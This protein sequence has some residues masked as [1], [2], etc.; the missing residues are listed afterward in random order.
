MGR[1]RFCS[2]RRC[3][4]RVPKAGLFC[5]RHASID[6]PTKKRKAKTTV[7]KKIRRLPDSDPIFE[8]EA[9]P[10]LIV[11]TDS[12]RKLFQL[13]S[14]RRYRILDFF[15]DRPEVKEKVFNYCEKVF[16]YLKGLRGSIVYGKKGDRYEVFQP[17]FVHAKPHTLQGTTHADIHY[18]ACHKTYTVWI[19]IDEVTEENGCVTM[20]LKSQ[21]TPIDYKNP[22]Q[23]KMFEKKTITGNCGKIVVFDGR[24]HHRSEA[25]TTDKMRTVL[26]FGLKIKHFVL[27]EVE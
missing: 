8:Y 5:S 26:T 12:L 7:A 17:C 15:K 25:N 23:D 21:G 6:Q 18:F 27:K 14:S 10:Q 11:D 13:N 22:H 20:F 16:S 4:I 3:R 24:L 9:S 1:G 19:P 2:K